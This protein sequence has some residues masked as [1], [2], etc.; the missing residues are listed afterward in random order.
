MCYSGR[1]NKTIHQ[2]WVVP[3]TSGMQTI[4]IHWYDSNCYIVFGNR[5]FTVL[6]YKCKTVEDRNDNNI[7]NKNL[8]NLDT[9]ISSKATLSSEARHSQY[10]SSISPPSCRQSSGLAQ[11]C[12]C[13]CRYLTFGSLNFYLYTL[14]LPLPRFS[15]SKQTH[16]HV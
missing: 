10:T 14:I 16:C 15:V 2:V 11:P 7:N 13:S 1:R 5:C 9:A 12:R 6:N 8:R 4:K 3:R